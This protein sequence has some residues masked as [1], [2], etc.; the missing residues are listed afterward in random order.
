MT[1]NLHEYFDWLTDIATN[2]AYT[3]SLE[4]SL[5]IIQGI[6]LIK[7]EQNFVSN[8][9]SNLLT[10]NNFSL[11]FMF[12]SSEDKDNYLKLNSKYVS[13]NNNSLK[14]QIDNSFDRFYT[15]LLF[16]FGVNIEGS[17]YLEGHNAFLT[18][19]PPQFGYVVNGKTNFIPLTKMGDV[20]RYETITPA[21]IL[22]SSKTGVYYLTEPSRFITQDIN[23]FMAQAIWGYKNSTGQSLIEGMIAKAKNHIEFYFKETTTNK[24]ELPI[25]SQ[26]VVTSNSEN[27]PVIGGNLSLNF[28]Y[29]LNATISGYNNILIVG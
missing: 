1:I 11:N 10:T 12:K 26:L 5:K 14:T 19:Q 4:T 13:Y 21:V 22:D 20:S 8:A 3:E 16:G 23:G 15:S 27:L 2:S 24:W 6:Y 17:R 25:N 28:V 7:Q 18:F 29:D 9:W